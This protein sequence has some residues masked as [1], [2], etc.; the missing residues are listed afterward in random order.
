[1]RYNSTAWVPGSS[2]SLELTQMNSFLQLSNNPLCVCTTTSLSIHLPVDIQ[3]ASMSQLLSIVLQW[4]LGYMC[5][6]QILVSSGYMPSSGIAG[7]SGSSSSSFLRNLHTVLHSGCTSL[8][9]HQ[10][11]KRVPFSPHPL[12]HLLFMDFLMMAILTGV[13]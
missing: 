1:M 8:L 12:Q 10:Q 13:R 9:S 6:F 5:L 2:I 7:A 4:T 11:C 3:V